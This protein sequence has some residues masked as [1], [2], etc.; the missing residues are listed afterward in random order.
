MVAKFWGG[1]DN[2]THFKW[3]AESAFIFAAGL[4]GFVLSAFRENIN[5]KNE[6]MKKNNFFPFKMKILEYYNEENKN[7]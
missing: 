1:C 5:V 4:L 7:T 3:K 2:R 6:K